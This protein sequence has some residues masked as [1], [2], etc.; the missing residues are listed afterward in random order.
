MLASY[1]PLFKPNHLSWLKINLIC[2]LAT[3]TAP[4]KYATNFLQVRSFIFFY[5]N[6][7]Y[8]AMS[9]VPPFPMYLSSHSSFHFVDPLNPSFKPTLKQTDQSTFLQG[10]SKLISP[11]F[12][13]KQS[14]TIV[15]TNGTQTKAEYFKTSIKGEALFKSFKNRVKKLFN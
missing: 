2:R 15:K 13:K 4:L 5:S 8:H 10:L 12:R 1:I 11:S 6:L 9:S 7:F 3:T 14:V